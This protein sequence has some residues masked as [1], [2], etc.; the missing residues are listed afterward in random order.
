MLASKKDLEPDYRIAKRA[1]FEC[2]TTLDARPALIEAEYTVNK[3]MINEHLAVIVELNKSAM[4]IR[5]HKM[6]LTK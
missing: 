5:D 4:I 1:I 2:Q 6:Q 3:E